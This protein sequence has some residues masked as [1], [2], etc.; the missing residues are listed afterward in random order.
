MEKQNDCRFLHEYSDI[1]D[2]IFYDFVVQVFIKFSLDCIFV[3]LKVLK[4]I[5]YKLFIKINLNLLM[6]E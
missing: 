2:I 4:V 3:A 6:E 5:S 1:Y